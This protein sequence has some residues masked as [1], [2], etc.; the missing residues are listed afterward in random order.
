MAG[1][2]G[3]TADDMAIQDALFAEEWRFGMEWI[4]RPFCRL[5]TTLPVGFLHEESDAIVV[6]AARGGFPFGPRTVGNARDDKLRISPMWSAMLGR[7]HC[8]VVTSGISEMVRDGDQ[9]TSYWFRRK[10]QKPIVMSGLL[11]ERSIKGS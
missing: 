7:S 5:T 4:P 10:D 2:I 3:L 8:L 6:E 11:G 1:L 9:K